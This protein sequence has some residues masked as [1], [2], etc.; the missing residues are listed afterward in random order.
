M[1]IIDFVMITNDELVYAVNDG[2][3][4]LHI[5]F[6]SAPYPLTPHPSRVWSGFHNRYRNICPRAGVAVDQTALGV[7]DL[8]LVV[9]QM[10]P[11]RALQL[12]EREHGLHQTG[13]ADRVAAGEQATGGIHGKPASIG[14]FE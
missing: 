8:E 12:P 14:Q 6:P 5:S 3:F 13:G 1:K 11:D 9:S 7:F 10:L 2:A 4:A